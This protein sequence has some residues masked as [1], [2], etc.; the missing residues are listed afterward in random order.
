MSRNVAAS[1][2]SYHR[3][4]V[5]AG[6]FHVGIGYRR[7]KGI[8]RAEAAG[9]MRKLGFGLTICAGWWFPLVVVPEA[10]DFLSLGAHWD[11]VDWGD[12]WIGAG[13]AA[14]SLFGYWLLVYPPMVFKTRPGEVRS[15][16]AMHGAKGAKDRPFARLSVS[17][18]VRVT[19][20]G[21]EELTGDGLLM[22]I[23]FGEMRRW[24]AY[25]RGMLVFVRKDS[26]R[27]SAS[28]NLVGDN[29]VLRP[30]WDGAAISMVWKQIEHPWRLV[31]RVVGLMRPARRRFRKARRLLRNASRAKAAGVRWEK[32]GWSSRAARDSRVSDRLGSRAVALCEREWDWMDEADRVNEGARHSSVRPGGDDVGSAVSESYDDVVRRIHGTDPA[33]RGPAAGNAAYGETRILNDAVWTYGRQKNLTG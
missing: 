16:F 32:V 20:L 27:S 5:L 26:V 7:F 29:W 21:C 9:Y 8:Y 33:A 30:D 24:P 1:G 31:F 11:L 25:S 23:P 10:L 22:R 18:V 13:C 3:P 19:E 4:R 12:F 15:F 17:V 6:P 14:L 2:D 28:C